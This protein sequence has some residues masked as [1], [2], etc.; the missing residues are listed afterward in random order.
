MRSSIAAA[1]LLAASCASAAWERVGLFQLA[2]PSELSKA[3]ALTGEM[4][5]NQMLGT[6]LAANITQLPGHKFFGPMREDGLMAFP[7]FID[8][9]RLAD[10]DDLGS[11]LEFAVVYPMA[12]PRAEFLKMHPGAVE[13]NG[14]ILV[15]R[16]VFSDSPGEDDDDV[17][18][19]AFSKDGKWA[20]ASDKPEQVKLAVAEIAP[21]T[22]PLK[23]DVCRLR[24]GGRGM[25]AVAKIYGA[26]RKSGGKGTPCDDRRAKDSFAR[27]SGATVALRVNRK[28]VEMRYTLK[29]IKGTEMDKC[30]TVALGDNPLAFAA[31]SAI[32]ANAA[33]IFEEADQAA[34]WAD[35]SRALD[36]AGLDCGKW[37]K[38]SF[39]GRTAAYEI[40]FARLL[41]HAASTNMSAGLDAEALMSEMN[42][43]KAFSEKP[44]KAAS[45][46]TFAS[47]S[48]SGLTPAM[49]PAARFLKVLPEAKGRKLCS[50]S[51]GSFAVVFRPVFQALAAQDAESARN[52]G[53]IASLMPAECD[54]GIASMGW[55]EK[56]A[57][58]CIVRISAE[59]MKALG[60][61]AAACTAAFMAKK[62]GKGAGNDADDADDG[63]DDDD[64]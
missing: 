22:S 12:L 26:L 24:I 44:L 31:P 58:K 50:A 56:G 57:L 10:T 52:L 46:P 55:R 42:A 53:M 1:V 61:V 23:G 11:A 14:L 59:E 63:A 40:D 6:M 21:I 13:T 64:D 30:G 47:L 9:S 3:V 60:N 36:K 38:A 41:K 4:T 49:S 19:V 37:I 51:A 8:T 39:T 45:A 34:V 27:I 16:N 25:E 35:V 48:V 28:G 54:G 43:I 2:G 33:S 29:T 15:K 7:L 20:V 62:S 17:S 18:Y 32:W 5:G